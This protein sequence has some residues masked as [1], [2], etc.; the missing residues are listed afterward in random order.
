MNQIFNNLIVSYEEKINMLETFEMYFLNK[1][2][3][4]S[5]L[6]Q[7]RAKLLLYFIMVISFAIVVIT[8]SMLLLS[9]YDV[10]SVQMATRVGL[11]LLGGI[12]LLFL[13]MGKY[14][15][16]ANVITIGA[17]ICIA[18]QLFLMRYASP[19][20]LVMSISIPS[21][22]IITA[23][24]L[25]TGKTIATVTILSIALAAIV[26]FQS[27]LINPEQAKRI[28]A[29]H[30]AMTVFISALCYLIMKNMLNAVSEITN[31]LEKNEEQSKIIMVLLNKAQE[32]TGQLYSSSNILSS[33]A[34]Q[35]SENA[36]NQA[37]F[38]E[39]MTA[40]IE[41]I[42]GGVD[43]IA[44]SSDMQVVD[45]DALAEKMTQFS[46]NI[47]GIKKEVE[48]SLNNARDIMKYAKLGNENLGIMNTSMSNIQ[49]SSLE[50][51]GII[52]MINDISDQINLLS[53]NA[54]IEAARAGDYGRGFAVV[55]DEISKLADKTSESVKN[56]GALINANNQ[57][58]EG[59]K[60]SVERT[61]DTINQIIGG[62]NANFEIMKM[63]AERMDNQLAANIE[64]NKDAMGVKTKTGNIRMATEEHK[65]A[66][67]EMVKT[68]SSLNEMTQENS[69]GAEETFSNTEEL[70]SMANQLKELVE[71]ID[72]K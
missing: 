59:G 41:E 29:L 65:K 25:S 51:T 47:E 18:I 68:I 10:V 7:R 1:Y 34:L 56:I 28:V 52:E 3:V 22:F 43:A 48:K 26:V 57:E 58:I 16:A 30:S 63:I 50:M 49:V 44:E 33:T 37:A 35:F 31:K 19:I 14:Y 32:L 13:R 20:E 72:R 39:E 55:A 4:S 8:T 66:T 38:I 71:S 2:S 62:V 5:I 42:S 45:M 24:L 9:I 36:Q 54:S 60:N 53:L 21:L 61:V 6:V 64:I 12:G 69:A 46:N 27:S 70:L 15:I 17:L 11:L 40:S 23:A 67:D